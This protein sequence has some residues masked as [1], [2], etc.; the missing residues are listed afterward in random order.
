MKLKPNPRDALGKEKMTEKI[1]VP[2]LG[3]LQ[4]ILSRKP[5]TQHTKRI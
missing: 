1:T 2:E 5:T 4:R 3:N